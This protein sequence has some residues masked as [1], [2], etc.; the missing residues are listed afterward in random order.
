MIETTRE[1][2]NFEL[3][4]FNLNNQSI[5][6]GV[7]TYLGDVI[8]AAPHDPDIL[9]INI[10]SPLNDSFAQAVPEDELKEVRNHFS[11]LNDS[12]AAVEKRS[13]AIT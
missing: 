10:S 12:T 4:N 9:K 11:K 2:F 6:N 5:R 3:P 8:K 13:T 1:T 7:G